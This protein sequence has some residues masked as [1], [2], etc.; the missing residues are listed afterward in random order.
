MNEVSARVREKS[1]TKYLVLQHDRME[2]E[3]NFEP[4]SSWELQF[5]DKFPL[6]VARLVH[7]EKK[8]WVR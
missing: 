2:E 7:G 8:G 5:F 6:S 4:V 1:L 3:N